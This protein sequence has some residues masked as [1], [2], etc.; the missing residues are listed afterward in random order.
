MTRRPRLV[1]DDSGA[2]LVLAL[3]LVSVISLL[4]LAVLSLAD[5]SVR[6]TVALRG[7]AAE[8]S[9]SDGAMTA[10]IN[11]IRNSSYN[12]A[13]GQH[14]FG[15]ADTVSLDAIAG[16]GAATVA[17]DPDPSKVLIQCPSLSMCNRPGSAIL[18]LGTNPAEDGVNITQPS[19]SI[20]RVH[21]VV[22]SNSN[23]DVVNGTLSTDT[24]VYA[25]TACAGTIVSNPSPASCNYGA[26]ANALGDD[27]NYAPDAASAPTYRALPACTTPNSL[28]TFL[29]GYYDDAF[30]LSSMMKSGSSCKNSTWWFKPGAYYFDFHN[31]GSNANPMLNS[32]GNVWTIDSGRLVA[33]TPV[34][35]AGQVIAAPP[36]PAT[37]PGSCDNPI[38]DANA[39]G[40]Q[41]VFGGDSQLS[42]KSGQAEICGTYSASKPP[43]AVY[44]LKTGA[45]SDTALAG[46]KPA[47]TPTQGG[48]APTATVVNLADVDGTKFASW[49]TGNNKNA[50]TTVS[51]PGYV[52]PA[53]IPAGSIL[54][55]AAVKVTHRHSDTGSTNKLDVTLTPNGGTA[56]TGTVTGINGS[57]TFRTDSV[58]MDTARTGA[59][60][61]AVYGGT[62]TGAT[63]DVKVSLTNK[64]DVEDIDAI[65][66]D[67]TYVAPAYRAG[68][69]CIT[70]GPYTGSG[71]ASRCALIT[72][73][74]SPNSQFYVQGTTYAPR[75]VVDVTLNN[76]TEQVFRFGVIARSLW[77]KLTG[78]FSFG[79]PVIEVPDDSPGFVFSVYLRVYLCASP[80]PCATSGTPALR[81]K[82]AFIDANPSA[83]APGKRQV[84]VLSWS[85]PR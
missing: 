79:G 56:L 83:P 48:F 18:T 49:N 9:T 54:K 52:P 40:V 1:R 75:A 37:I 15:T 3:V 58:P 21:G 2:A 12:N 43:V 82:V 8:A 57:S 19:G 81:A 60:A 63:I 72:S 23:L 16:T 62:F 68:T 84:S 55:S 45:E 14:C 73:E 22:F 31:S 29:P 76:A 6:T 61:T 74:G 71:N 24:A 26:T 66:L 80:G 4:L 44:G 25:R 32:T 78:S 38:K 34:N 77:V 10:A 27:P 30:G 65:Q 47:G 46:L 11:T 7:Q 53:A 20:F 67:L 64:N 36:V 70:A 28:I 50:N 69:G 39:L 41:F 33:G 17:C 5:T 85:S 13:A 42:V 51:V 35:P 59:L